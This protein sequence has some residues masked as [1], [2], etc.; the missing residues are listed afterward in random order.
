LQRLW[1][2]GPGLNLQEGIETGRYRVTREQTRAVLGMIAGGVIGAMFAVL[3]GQL[4]WRS[5]GTDTV[6]LLLVALGIDRDEA[7]RIAAVELPP[8]PPVQ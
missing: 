3:D 4:T 1:L 6:E 8:L 2:A 7:R 5:A